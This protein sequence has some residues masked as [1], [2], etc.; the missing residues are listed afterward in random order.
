MAR[1][2]GKGGGGGGG[3][4]NG[5]DENPW[6]NVGGKKIT[7]TD[8]PD[9][10]TASGKSE[11]IYAADGGDWVY[12]GGGDDLVY[13][14]GGDDNLYGEDGNDVLNGGFGDDFLFGGGGRD[15]LQG[16]DGNDTLHGDA[17]DD[18]LR[19]GDGDDDLFG[20]DGNDVLYGE[21]GADDLHGGSGADE[22]VYEQWY[23]STTD[24][25]GHFDGY[26]SA[27]G[28]DTIRDFDTAQG[29]VLDL[30]QIDAIDA[31]TGTS[32]GQND[33]FTI[34]DEFTGNGGE[35]VLSYNGVTNIT[36]IE[37]DLDGDRLADV[38]INMVGDHSAGGEWLIL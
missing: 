13:G 18:V 11:T 10:I 2:E 31:L 38:T 6:A 14:E 24:P 5:T 35:L 33:A 1:P 23:H 32:D 21:L 28:V 37:G 25:Y 3:G 4:D 29:D 20:G 7:G 8:G 16:G 26:S 17:G 12:A 30:S 22:F 9:E 34:V 36:T 19:G 27:P 15:A